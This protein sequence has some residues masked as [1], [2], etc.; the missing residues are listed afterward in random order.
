MAAIETPA[1]RP[2]VVVLPPLLYAVGFVLGLIVELIW[3]TH[4]AGPAIRFTAGSLLVI[5]GLL[6]MYSGL[7]AFQRAGTNIEVYRPA[8]ALVVS[9]PYRYARNPI[10]LAMTVAYLGAAL[11]ADNAWVLVLVVPIV[12]IMHFGVILREERYLAAKFGKTYQDYM[13]AVR[14]WL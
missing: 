1:D 13:H 14:R 5:A 12:L 10:Y 3:R 8:T 11:L 9:G 6:I 7:R 4:L 2:Q